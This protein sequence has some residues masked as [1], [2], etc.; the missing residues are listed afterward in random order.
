M[1]GWKN[2]A[3]YV[4]WNSDNLI[5]MDDWNIHTTQVISVFDVWAT[6]DD[7]NWR[8]PHYPLYELWKLKV[9]SAFSLESAERIVR[10]VARRDEDNFMR[11]TLHHL[12]IRETQV[13]IY[14]TEYESL[15]EYLY[16]CDGN[17]LDKRTYPYF[18]S[19]FNGRKPEELRFKEGDM[20]EAVFDDKAL[21]GIVVGLPTSEEAAARINQGMSRLD[22]SDDCYIVLTGEGVTTHVDSL[23]VF[24]PQYK[25]SSRTE[26]KMR[27]IYRDFISFDARVKIENTAGAALLRDCAEEMGWAVES[28]SMPQ[29]YDGL[30]LKLGGVPGFKDGITLLVPRKKMTEHFDRIRTSFLR[31]AGKPTGGRGYS[32]KRKEHLT[33]VD[34]AVYEL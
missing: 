29:W 6:F 30:E 32:L 13:G 9:G 34:E 20:C 31:M 16:D 27:R 7:R 14:A 15:S 25:I 33:T 19:Q 10:E 28:L 5:T 24:K 2:P 22:P 8:K 17:L 23:K 26:S 3:G 11:P 1:D 18:D 4:R 12:C 21:L